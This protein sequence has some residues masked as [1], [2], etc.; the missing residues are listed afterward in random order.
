MELSN[1]QMNTAQW[2]ADLMHADGITPEMMANPE[3]AARA[4]PAYMETIAAKIEKIQTKYL[5]NGQARQA[6]QSFIAGN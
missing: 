1:Q 3:F 6:M 5:V 2:V 4:I